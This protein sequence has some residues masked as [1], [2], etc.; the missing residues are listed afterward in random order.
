MST[1][2]QQANQMLPVPQQAPEVNPEQLAEALGITRDGLAEAAYP[3][4][5]MSTA[6]QQTNQMPTRPAPQLRQAPGMSLDQLLQAAQFAVGNP[7]VVV[8]AARELP[9]AVG[10]VAEWLPAS[11]LERALE[12]GGPLLGMAGPVVR[13]GKKA[14]EAISETATKAAKRSDSS[15]GKTTTAETTEQAAKGS[16]PGTDIDQVPETFQTKFDWVG[17]R[18]DNGWPKR[19]LDLGGG[20]GDQ[21]IKALIKK[22]ISLTVSDPQRLDDAAILLN[23]T[24]RPYGVTTV[25]NVL[26]VI[27]EPGAR[28]GVYESAHHSTEPGGQIVFKVYQ[29]NK[30]W[31]RSG[32]RQLTHYSVALPDKPTVKPRKFYDLPKAEEYAQSVGSK[33]DENWQNNKKTED[34]RKEI[35]KY[36]GKDSIEHLSGDYII[37]RNPQRRHPDTRAW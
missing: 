24:K 35:E 10:G 17:N 12:L 27:K 30:E 32:K 3:T 21:S 9:G 11:D 26:N 4:E 6:A 36:F 2:T 31:A 20:R 7:D 37:V 13:G 33:I 34:Y 5:A 18:L 14:V 29:G 23:A 15:A 22:G 28:R 1:A 16:S 8:Q 25:N 19:V